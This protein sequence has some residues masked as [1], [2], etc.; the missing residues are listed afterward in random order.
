MLIL[1]LSWIFMMDFMKNLNK[2]DKNVSKVFFSRS[3]DGKGEGQ[4]P[5][6]SLW[7]RMDFRTPSFLSRRS[8]RSAV[9]RFFIDPQGNQKEKACDHRPRQYPLARLDWRG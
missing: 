4:Y 5:V 3:R 9:H 2:K 6:G 8:S 7:K 1:L